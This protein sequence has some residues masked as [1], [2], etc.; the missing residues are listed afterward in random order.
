MLATSIRNDLTSAHDW[1]GTDLGHPSGWSHTLRLSVEFV[2]ATPL[3]LMLDWSERHI[4]V[5]NEAYAALGGTGHARAPGGRIPALR[6]APVSASPD[7]FAR[8][9]AGAAVQLPRQALTLIGTGGVQQLVLDLHL[10]PV[11]AEDGAVHGV[12]CAL[13]PSAPAAPAPTAVPGAAL[14]VLVVEDNPDAQYLVCEMLQAFGHVAQ[15]VGDGEQALA[16][17]GQNEYDVLFTDVSLPG[18]SGVEVARMA[19]GAQPALHV[20]FA[21]GYGDTLLRHLD[22]PYVSLQK[23]YELDQLQTALH[24]VAPFRP[25]GR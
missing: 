19:V 13:V 14:R 24:A 4:V 1:T 17:L 9:W 15:G 25:S 2:L 23:P 6:C 3:P 22:F 10:T 12:L 20:I 7:G 18:M 16:L 5:C 11:R 8:A 21:S